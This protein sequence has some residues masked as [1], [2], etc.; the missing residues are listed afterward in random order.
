[1]AIKGGKIKNEKTVIYLRLHDNC[2]D[3]HFIK[4][5]TDCNDFCSS[6]Y[7]TIVVTDHQ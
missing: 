1:M 4:K 5:G 7:L 2:C 3:S 6:K